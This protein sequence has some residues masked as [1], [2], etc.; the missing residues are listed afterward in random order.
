[1]AVDGDVDGLVRCAVVHHG[2]RSSWPPRRRA[3]VFH[4]WRAPPSRGGYSTTKVGEKSAG[5]SERRV[6]KVSRLAPS[7]MWIEGPACR[8]SSLPLEQPHRHLD[9]H[10]ALQ[11]RE[12]GGRGDDAVALDPAIDR[13]GEVVR[14]HADPAGETARPEQADRGAGGDGAAHD[15]VDVGALLQRLLHQDQLDLAPG[16]APLAHDDVDG[17][18]RERLGEP[19]LDEVRPLRFA[20]AGKPRHLDRRRACGME[21]GEVGAGHLP[22]GDPRDRRLGADAGVGDVVDHGDHRDLLAD[23]QHRLGQPVEAHRPQRQDVRLLR[24]VGDLGDLAAEVGVAAGLHD[25]ERDAETARLLD[26][27]VVHAQP[28]GILEVRVGGADA[29]LP[30]RLGEWAVGHRGLGAAEIEGRRPDLERPCGRRRG[31]LR[32]LLRRPLRRACGQRQAGEES[33]NQP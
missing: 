8:C 2:L 31:V 22:H 19:L 17:A 16:V 29:P 5:A 10:A 23:R 21:A 26:H 12:V 3:G 18:S 27:A 20:R 24:A 15:V 30:R 6:L 13:V 28:V 14:K 1:M 4:T 11:R 32:R 33:E 25:A 9:P 7:T